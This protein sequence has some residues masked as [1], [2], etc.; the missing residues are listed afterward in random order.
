LY[1]YLK[2]LLKVEGETESE[3]EVEFEDELEN[4]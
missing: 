4:E 1:R 3:D 2:K